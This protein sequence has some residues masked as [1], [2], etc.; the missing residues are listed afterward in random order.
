[1]NFIQKTTYIF[2]CFIP[3]DG[4]YYEDGIFHI[5]GLIKASGSDNNKS[6]PYFC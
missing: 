5:R 1:M 4:M 6:M 3:V 2:R